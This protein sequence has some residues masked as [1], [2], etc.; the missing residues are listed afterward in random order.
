MYA[1]YVDR[2]K[3]ENGV[4]RLLHMCY[5]L[6]QGLVIVGGGRLVPGA[7]SCTLSVMSER[8]FTPVYCA[9]VCWL[10]EPL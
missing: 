5:A 7:R 1:L 4:E 3:S 9:I 6:L 8:E 10:A 2:C